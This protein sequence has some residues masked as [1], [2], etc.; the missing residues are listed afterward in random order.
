MQ[1]LRIGW[2][3]QELNGW[4]FVLASVFRTIGNPLSRSLEGP[5]ALK[6]LTHHDQFASHDG[7]AYRCYGT[8]IRY[9]LPAF[10]VLLFCVQNGLGQIVAKANERDSNRFVSQPFLRINETNA[11]YDRSEG[12]YYATTD[13]NRSSFRVSSNNPEARIFYRLVSSNDLRADSDWRVARDSSL[14]FPTPV[15]GDYR[16]Q[17]ALGDPRGGGSA[18]YS[19][20]YK[21][22]HPI[23]KWLGAGLLVISSFACVTI[24][25]VFVSGIIRTN[26][27]LEQRV[28]IRTAEVIAAHQEKQKL[29]FELLQ[30]QKMESLG[31]LA[32]GMAHDFN[33]SLCAICSNAELALLSLY[34]E[35]RRVQRHIEEVMAASHQAAEL[36][37]SLLTFAGKSPP[38][39][40]AKLLQEVVG[41]S[42]RMIRSAIP[43]SIKITSE[44][45]SQPLWSNV[46]ETQINQVIINLVMNARDAMLD[47]GNLR[48]SL[49]VPSDSERTGAVLRLVDDG[50]GMDPATLDRVF[51]PF[52]TTKSRGKGTGLGM[53]M[54]HSIVTAHDGTVTLN[55]NPNEG[56]IVEIRLP[57]CPPLAV[58]AEST[59]SRLLSLKQFR[60][61]V[62]VAD[63]EQRVRKALVSM[64]ES[65]G[66]TVIP[67]S[68]G[69]QLID[70]A[71]EHLKDLVL[72]ATDCEMPEVS[73]VSAL[74]DVRQLAPQVPAILFTGQGQS[75]E[76]E[77]ELTV[78]MRKP[79]QLS[80]ILENAKELIDR[81]T[82]RR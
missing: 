38:R 52:F 58:R 4:V 80:S 6:T 45:T 63:D 55:S 37:H 21:V 35:P 46:D 18:L 72:I 48:L 36:T 81:T 82:K 15:P 12:R 76:A 3:L 41:N 40:E 61:T 65:M 19:V 5:E 13:R 60:G 69:A 30:A 2:K 62:I 25:L 67:A 57:T 17:M 32:A 1:W 51:E 68:D 31:T 22:S 71:K 56:T 59:K 10:L 43:A 77:D 49:E 23:A 66:L 73:G 16:L 7:D 44:L 47:G 11:S 14:E 50:I 27:R 24:G 79:F 8:P 28:K 78:F 34:H 9:F 20:P 33:N 54:V 39:R 29:E 75:A 74:K 42:L 64:F 26:R 53:S 70:R